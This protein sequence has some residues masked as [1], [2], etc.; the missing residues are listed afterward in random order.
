MTGI[1]FPSSRRR[2]NKE[3]VTPVSPSRLLD[4]KSREG[5]ATNRGIFAAAGILAVAT[6]VAYSNSFSGP[7]I[8]DDITSIAL[9]SDRWRLYIAERN[10]RFVYVMAIRPDG[11]LAAA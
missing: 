6:L 7:F 9:S 3:G 8:F 11:T 10:R 4:E 1:F 5:F 2:I